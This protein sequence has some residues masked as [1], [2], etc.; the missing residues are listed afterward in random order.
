MSDTKI[1]QS[2]AKTPKVKRGKED[3]RDRLA[4]ALRANLVKRKRQKQ[5]RRDKPCEDKGSDG[6]T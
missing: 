2:S 4:T 3:R 6:D 5:V 1:P